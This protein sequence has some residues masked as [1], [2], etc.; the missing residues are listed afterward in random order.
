M[1]YRSDPQE[2]YRRAQLDAHIEGSD[3]IGLTSLCLDRA[4]ADLDLALSSSAAELSEARNQVLQRA[5][6]ALLALRHG[7]DP[8]SPMAG[9]LDAFYGSLYITISR[10]VGNWQDS[11]IRKARGDLMDIRMLMAA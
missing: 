1:H 4:I 5:A 7:T 10:S 3:G 11:D 2:S 9:Q 6:K 8:N